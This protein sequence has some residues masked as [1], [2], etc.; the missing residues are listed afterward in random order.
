MSRP[1]G[2]TMRDLEGQAE[3]SP[4]TVQRFA[5]EV[6]RAVGLALDPSRSPELAALI[7]RESAAAELTPATWVARVASRTPIE[8]ARMMSELTVNET[9]FFR[10][11]DQ[12]DTFY[13]H[14]LPERIAARGHVRRLRILSAACSSGEEPY[15]IA[16]LLER[17]GGLLAGWDVEVRAVDLH[18][19]SLARARRGIFAEW[20]LRDTP[21]AERARWFTRVDGREGS[22]FELSAELRRRVVF[23]HVNLVAPPATLWAEPW[24]FIFCR[25]ALMYFETAQAE[26]IVARIAASLVPGGVLFLGHAETLRTLC[27]AGQEPSALVVEHRDQTFFYRRT[28]APASSRPEARP[29]SRPE[30]RYDAEPDSVRQAS[31]APSTELEDPDAHWSTRIAEAGK[32][33]AELGRAAPFASRGPGTTLEDAATPGH[34]T[35]LD[36]V[37]AAIAADDIAGAIAALDALPPTLAATPLAHLVRAV[38]ALDQG[39]LD[40]ATDRAESL[41]RAAPDLST[42]ATARFVLALAAEARSDVSR[43]ADLH[44]SASATDPAFALPELHL[45]RLL[46]R[47]GDLAA[48]RTA[49][50]RALARLPGETAERIALFAR[51]FPNHAMIA[52]CEAELAAL[53]TSSDMRRSPR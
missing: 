7:L 2:R 18:E 29:E 39:R 10:N 24:D 32:R 21:P 45:G 14:L 8:L 23:E 42:Q 6:T 11:L 34:P 40:D 26:A 53:T 38:T 17:L 33:I 12:F 19:A 15:T 51:G 41:A 50:E 13:T 49:L 4:S 43:A 27:R 22:G 36:A 37:L 52:S 30:S 35:T 47:Q 28:V 31:L 46:R 25:N 20:T 44:R 5:A 3:P 48:S 1:A 16:M 9:H